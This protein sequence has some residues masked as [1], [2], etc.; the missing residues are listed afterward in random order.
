M[1]L[2]LRELYE[3][4]NLIPVR[5]AAPLGEGLTAPSRSNRRLRV[6]SAAAAEAISRF[7]VSGSGLITL[8]G[9]SNALGVVSFCAFGHRI[10]SVRRCLNGVLTF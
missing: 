1:H 6:G 3:N 8:D 4:G 9:D 5:L 2:P 10:I 7:L